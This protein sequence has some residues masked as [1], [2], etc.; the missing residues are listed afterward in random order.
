MQNS[1]LCSL[2]AEELSTPQL[3]KAL[4]AGGHVIYMRHAI[5]SHLQ[6]DRDRENFNDC[7]LQRNLSNEGKDQ[8]VR[9]GDL[10]KR[11]GIPIGEVISSPYCRC[12]ETAKLVFG[13][14]KVD[15]NL[16]FSISKDKLESQR[17]GKYLYDLMMNIS[18]N[19]KNQVLVG[20][21]SNLKDGLGVWPKPEG[22]VAIFHKQ[23]GKMIYKGMIKPDEWLEI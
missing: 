3:I 23:N 1:F 18:S 19:Q 17:L 13:E 5:T 2:S 4:Q 21:T 16:G 10:I 11:L 8:A 6:K 15:Q 22:V 20:H 12:K 9:I 7:S 14:Y